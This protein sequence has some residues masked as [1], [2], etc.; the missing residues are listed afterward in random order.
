MSGAV[1]FINKLQSFP[2][3][4]QQNV[5]NIARNRKEI[6]DFFST[7]SFLSYRSQSTSHIT[8]ARLVFS[9]RV[10]IIQ[11]IRLL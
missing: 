11:S 1:K 2:K 4:S 6:S 9:I 8:Q 3:L 5:M 10:K 7:L